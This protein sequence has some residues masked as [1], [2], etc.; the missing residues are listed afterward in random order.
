[1]PILKTI[2]VLFNQEGKIMYTL[3]EKRLLVFVISISLI[4][5]G[6]PSVSEAGMIGT[7]ALIEAQG[8]DQML[9]RIDTYITKENVR[10]QMIALGVDPADVR[11]RL[12]A[13]TNDELRMLD[14]KL[15][16]MPAAGES[17]PAF[18]YAFILILTFVLTLV[19]LAVSQGGAGAEQP[20]GLGDENE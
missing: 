14:G 18:F 17:M 20:E 7:Q 12:S 6:V 15:D 10:N 5:Y 2:E 9:T 3:L 1:L 11:Q 13:L 8:R 16:S 19:Q 4:S